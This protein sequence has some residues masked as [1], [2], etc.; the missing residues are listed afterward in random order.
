MPKVPSA[1]F[2]VLAKE[3]KQ[4]SIETHGTL[5]RCTLCDSGILLDEEHQRDHIKQHIF[6]YKHQKN[7]TTQAN[8]S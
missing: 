4:D 5:I 7:K 3:F 2:S 6:N 8:K 1:R